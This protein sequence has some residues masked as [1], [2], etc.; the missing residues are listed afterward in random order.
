MVRFWLKLP[1]F[2]FIIA[3]SLHH[4]KFKFNIFEISDLLRS[5][6]ASISENAYMYLLPMFGVFWILFWKLF[7]RISCLTTA[8]LRFF[9]LWLVICRAN[10]TSLMASGQKFSL[11]LN[12]K[13]SI[14]KNVISHWFSSCVSFNEGG[15][16]I[17]IDRRL[18]H[19]NFKGLL[20]FASHLDKPQFLY[21]CLSMIPI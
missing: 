13:A 6:K 8:S 15:L 2:L 1:S 17:P 19:M 10:F 14:S 4:F 12:F 7:Q 9:I 5:I 11:S 18:P 16:W 20:P 3:I 21:C